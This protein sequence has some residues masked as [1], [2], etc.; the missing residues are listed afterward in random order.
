MLLTRYLV[1]R[2]LGLFTIMLIGM[3]AFM[4]GLDLMVNANSVLAVETEGPEGGLLCY[5]ALRF[6]IIASDLIKFAALLAGLLTFNALTRSG[7]LAAISNAGVSQRGV[8]ARLLPLGLLFAG[9][10]FVVDD[11]LVPTSQQSLREW[12]V[13]D[14]QD[15]NTPV[16]TD[17]V[18]WVQVGNDIVRV[19]RAN[20][21]DGGLSKFSIFERDQAGT[22]LAQLMVTEAWPHPDGWR[23]T[24]VTTRH[25]DDLRVRYDPVLVWDVDLDPQIFRD[26]LSPPRELSLGGLLRLY[27]D[28]V[29]GNWA[30]ELY[31]TWAYARVADCLVPF[32]VLILSVVLAR[33]SQRAGNAAILLLGGVIIG[34]G[35]FIFNGVTL[36]MGEAGLLPP[37]LA[38]GIPPSVLAIIAA[39]GSVWREGRVWPA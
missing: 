5:T 12:G 20:I 11:A 25:V 39:T 17:E 33:Q 32:L 16:G 31:G 15:A 1:R 34:F 35:F 24:G 23:L 21:A 14:D 9:L 6:P 38:A 4:L 26:L 36:A 13:V 37:L 28:A 18:V 27:G 2:T 10:Q 22:L 7:E 3:C 19:P 8:M 29:R 30:P